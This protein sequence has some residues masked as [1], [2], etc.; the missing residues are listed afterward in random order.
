MCIY[1]Y[2]YIYIYISELNPVP[3]LIFYTY[4]KSSPSFFP[5]NIEPS[6]VYSFISPSVHVR[7]SLYLHPF[8]SEVVSLLPSTVTCVCVSGS[9]VSDSL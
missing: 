6:L 2:I 4:L 5:E 1:I 7:I 8:F 9:V 3:F